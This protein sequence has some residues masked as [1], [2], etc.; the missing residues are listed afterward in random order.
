MNKGSLRIQRVWV[1]QCES[2]AQTH[3][4]NGRSNQTK[5]EGAIVKA[6]IQRQQ[7][8]LLRESTLSPL[9]REILATLNE[10]GFVLNAVALKCHREC[11]TLFQVF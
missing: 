7:I 10:C 1:R 3:Q 9:I 8:S 11:Y 5:S 6:L 2:L 4:L